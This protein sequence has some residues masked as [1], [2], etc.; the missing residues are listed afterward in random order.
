MLSMPFSDGCW[1]LAYAQDAENDD[2]LYLRWAAAYQ[3]RMGFEEFKGRLGTGDA[4]EDG[5]TAEE[6]LDSVRG[7]IG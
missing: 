7:I 2:R 1:L 3:E 6:I 4:P 5:R